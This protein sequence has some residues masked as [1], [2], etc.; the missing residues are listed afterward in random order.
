MYVAFFQ[1]YEKKVFMLT[2]FF[3]SHIFSIYIICDR[4]Y[5]ICKFLPMLQCIKYEDV[6]PEYITTLQ[7]FR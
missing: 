1:D 2:F 6:G 4:E 3:A 5:D 7:K